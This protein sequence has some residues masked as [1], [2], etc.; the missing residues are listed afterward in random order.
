MVQFKISQIVP[1]MSFVAYFWFSIQSRVMFAFSSPV[2][3]VSL[4]ISLAFPCLHSLPS[5][6]SP[7]QLSPRFLLSR[8][9]LSISGKNNYMGD[10][11]PFPLPQIWTMWRQLV[12]LLMRSML[13]LWL[14]G[15][16]SQGSPDKQNPQEIYIYKIRNWLKWLQRL[17]NPTL[18]P[19]QAGEL[20]RPV[21]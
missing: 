17:R 18:C 9:R 5:L 7:D 12:P 14:G 11:A 8:F 10:V 1:I 20:E 16:I 2:S 6:K 4:T 15:C 3:W 21:V 19:Q 13:P